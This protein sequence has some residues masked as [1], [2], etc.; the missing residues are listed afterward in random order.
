MDRR[1][2]TPFTAILLGSL[3]VSVPGP[4]AWAQNADDTLVVAVPQSPSALEPVL[5]N[6]TSTLQTIYSVFDRRLSHRS[7]ASGARRILGPYRSDH[8]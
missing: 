4:T 1:H 6:N 5:R 8:L 2:L 3:A 7:G